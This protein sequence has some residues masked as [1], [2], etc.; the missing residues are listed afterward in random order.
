MYPTEMHIYVY[1]L[2]CTLVLIAAVFIEILI[3][4]IVYLSNGILDSHKN[5]KFQLDTT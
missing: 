5:D 3:N 1:F 2:N 4:I